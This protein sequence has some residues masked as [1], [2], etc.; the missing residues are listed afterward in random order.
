MFH[1]DTARTLAPGSNLWPL[2]WAADGHQYTTFYRT[3]LP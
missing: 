2:T 1:D 3:R